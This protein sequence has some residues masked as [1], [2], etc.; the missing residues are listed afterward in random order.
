MKKHIQEHYLPPPPNTYF[1]VFYLLDFVPSLF[2]SQDTCSFT[3]F[4]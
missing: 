3:F 1:V 4:I 2:L